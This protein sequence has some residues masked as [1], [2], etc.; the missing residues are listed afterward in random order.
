MPD[1]KSKLER[2]EEGLYSRGVS[3]ITKREHANLSPHVVDVKRAWTDDEVMNEKLTHAY[4][5]KRGV[6]FVSKFFVAS[7]VFFL[8]ASGIAAYM[9]LGGFNVISSKNVDITVQGPVSVA[10]GEEVVLEVTLHNNNNVDLEDAKL[11]IEYP[12]G[13][14]EPNN[15]TEERIRTE[16]SIGNITSGKTAIRTI[17][18]VFFGEKDSIKQL[19]ISTDYKAKGSNAHFNKEKFY[20]ISIK[21]SPIVVVVDYPKEINANQEVEFNVSVTSNSTETIQDLLL[22]AEYPFGFIFISANPAATFDKNVW[23]IGDLKSK[24]TKTFSIKGR[25]EAQ[26]DEER[27]V[28]FITGLADKNDERRIAV[29]F[30]NL[31][32]SVLIKKPFIGLSVSLNRQKEMEHAMN[33]GGEV[34]GE[35]SW[36]NNL[37][38]SIDNA[39]IEVKFTGAAFDKNSVKPGVGFFRST[40][41]RIVWDKNSV[42]SLR[43]IGP[44]DTGNLSFSYTLVDLDDAASGPTKNVSMN[45]FVTMTGTRIVSGEPNQEIV[46]ESLH[47]V[48]ISTEPDLNTRV[49]RS[50]GPFENSGPIPPKAEQETTY[51]VLWTLSNTFNDIGN[52]IVQAKLPVYMEWKGLVS[53]AGAVSYDPSSRIVTWTAGEIKAG[54]GHATLAKEVAFQ[55]GL[56]PSTSQVGDAPVLVDTTTLTTTDRYTGKQITITKGKL[57]TRFSTDPEFD[58]GD[59]K[60]RN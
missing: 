54:V 25:I 27:T 3:D 44:G 35:I 42:N 16:E 20:D 34:T 10:A 30:I 47:V 8:I 40:E 18:A 26:N 55:V 39:E 56:E 1:E 48:K 21:S 50:V 22:R 2:A 7:I 60:V 6:S 38:V 14:R 53:P 43:S 31:T 13:T 5:E 33:A 24:E 41:N 11:V 12:Q 49:V 58:Q 51:T 57:N 23:K 45:A 4:E 36:I 28:R 15:L 19:K 32:N 37:P 59:E 29:D 17:R 52:T 46:S 9:I